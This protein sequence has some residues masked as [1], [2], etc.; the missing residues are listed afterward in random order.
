MHRNYMMMKIPLAPVRNERT[1]NA[2]EDV[3][4]RESLAG[5]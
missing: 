1:T 4:K 2:T 3:R 5:G